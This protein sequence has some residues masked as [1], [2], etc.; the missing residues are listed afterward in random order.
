MF[1]LASMNTIFYGMCLKGTRLNY[2]EECDIRYVIIY[3]KYRH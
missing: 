3:E 2:K 1:K